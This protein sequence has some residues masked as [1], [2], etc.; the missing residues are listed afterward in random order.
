MIV[1]PLVRF[2]ILLAL[3]PPTS[4]SGLLVVGSIKARSYFFV[5]LLSYLAAIEKSFETST[6]VLETLL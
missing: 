2:M 5:S 1:L 4:N 3:V 6:T